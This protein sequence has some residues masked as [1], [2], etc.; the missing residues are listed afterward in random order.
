MAIDASNRTGNGAANRRREAAARIATKVRL[1]DSLGQTRL[2]KVTSLLHAFRTPG[3]PTKFS[4]VRRELEGQGIHLDSGGF[5]TETRSI[6]AVPA[7]SNSLS[8]VQLTSNPPFLVTTTRS[9]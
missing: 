5:W 8:A 2:T 9:R 4:E 6:S 7:Y 3:T 1:A